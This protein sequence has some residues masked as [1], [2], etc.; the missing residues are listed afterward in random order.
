MVLNM[1]A[2]RCPEPEGLMRTK[3]YRLELTDAERVELL[4]LR[5]VAPEQGFPTPPRSMGPHRASLRRPVVL[6]L[7]FGL[8]LVATRQPSQ[9][10]RCGAIRRRLVAC[11]WSAAHLERDDGKGHR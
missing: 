9:A 6:P 2:L 11:C 8:P 1:R 5:E 7:L 10:N 4:L 3:Q